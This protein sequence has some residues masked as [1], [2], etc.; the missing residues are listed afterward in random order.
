[1]H[2][3]YNKITFSIRDFEYGEI[4][5][6]D[7]KWNMYHTILVKQCFVE[8]LSRMINTRF[9]FAFIYMNLIFSS[10]KPKAQM[11]FS[12]QNLSVVVVNFSHF[13]LVL[14][15]HW[16]NFNQTWHK[17]S[18][19]EGDSKLFKWRVW[20]LRWEGRV[21]HIIQKKGPAL[22]KGEIIT[23]LWKCTDKI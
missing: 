14:Q 8:L 1:M 19:G 9:P 10:P 21:Y 6:V 11:N 13:H 17:A 18:L 23:K 20:F 22:F 3:M 7:I 4:N 2:V 12:D 5:I 15:N 16:P